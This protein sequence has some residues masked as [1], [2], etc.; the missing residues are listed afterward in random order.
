MDRKQLCIAN[1]QYKKPTQ[2]ESKRANGL[3]RYLTYREGRD[4]AA[5]QKAGR[6]RWTDHGL[7][8]TVTEIARSCEALKSQHVLLFSLVYNVNPDLMAMV[9]PAQREQF[10]RELTEQTTE[11]FFEARGID[12]GVEWA[13]VVHHR[14]TDNP[15]SPGQHNPHT[16][17]VLPGTFFNDDL[18][19]RAPLYF[20]QN[21]SV[22]H[23]G[24]LHDLT[25]Q[26]VADQM[27]RYVGPDWDARCDVLFANR[28]QQK[29]VVSD[30]PDSWLDDIDMPLWYGVRQTDERTSAAGYYTL[31]KDEVV[32]RPL[33]AGLNHE[34]AELLARLMRLDADHGLESFK[35]TAATVE[36]MTKP[37]R[38]AFF[39]ELRGINLDI[40][41]P[42]RTQDWDI[43][44]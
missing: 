27:E 20:T 4:E 30:T 42:S 15:Q 1:V 9:P 14:L 18:G 8:G 33:F 10:V 38:A 7:G 16:H 34:E 36:Q 13:Y 43:D 12:T 39:N 31:E 25:E 17:V 24:L 2:N 3:L 11:T 21:K 37:E 29:R 44:R 26:Q 35:R 6:E 5:R 41:T 28:E 22:N 23:I 19:D 32:F 40:Q